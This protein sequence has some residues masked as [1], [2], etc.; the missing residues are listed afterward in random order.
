[1]IDFLKPMC[2]IL[3]L[4]PNAGGHANEH[5]AALLA[6]ELG[7]TCRTQE[8]LSLKFLG[9]MQRATVLQIGDP[10]C[11][12]LSLSIHGQRCLAVDAIFY[13]GVRGMLRIAGI[14]R[15]HG[16]GLH[17]LDNVGEDLLDIVVGISGNDPVDELK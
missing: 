1:V 2:P 15:D 17:L 8:V 10:L 16:L 6:E 11:G 3:Y 5:I 7:V 14:P 9:P 4:L 13:K 12:H